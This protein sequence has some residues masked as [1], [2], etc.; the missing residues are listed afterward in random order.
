VADGW[1]LVVI[2]GLQAGLSLTL[3][4]ADTAFQDEATYL[5]AGH[6]EIAHWLHGSA[7]PAFPAY[8]SGAP[9]LYP[10]VGALAD[11]LGGLA[12]A[13][14]LS[15]L[16]MLGATA[17][18]WGSTRRL[19]G[20]RA[21]F[22]AAVLFV[23]LAPTLHLGT[24]ATYD[25]MSLFLLALATWF[26]VRAGDSQA[27]TRWLVGAGVVLAVANAVAY[28]SAAFDVVVILLALLIPMR[29]LGVKT[30]V[31]RSLTVLIV[32]GVLITAGLLIGGSE[33]THGVD[34]TTLQR[35]PGT[36]TALDV[37]G[38]AWTWTGAVLVAGACGV[39]ISWFRHEGGTQTCQLAVVTAAA[40][41]GPL[42]Q[43]RLHTAASLDK[44]VGAGAWFATIAAGYAVDK[45]IGAAPSG[46]GR[47][48]TS[49]ACV[50]A[51]ALPIAL[52]VSQ[53]RGFATSWPE[54]SD[55]VA[56]L[57]PLITRTT[58]PVLVE[59]PTVAEYYL[60]AES[61]WKRWS[62]TR[63]I[64]LPSGL[65]SGGPSQA[66]GVVGSGN[67]GT[68]AAKITS[69]YFDLVALNFTDTTWLDRQIK[70]DLSKSGRYRLIRVVP[71]G[72]IPGTN[73]IGTYLIWQKDVT[74]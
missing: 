48:V 3:V 6:L 53:A 61:Q 59:D 37:L 74:A 72:P 66:A 20:R 14:I 25:A 2:L 15:L 47:V 27:A 13:R 16:F 67:A 29:Q 69:G 73:V 5:W 63:N 52:G 71:Y 7:I 9:V 50:V 10:P 19:L 46:N 49:A 36:A 38:D 70:A 54:S 18:L 33:Y 58:G 62:S 28:A 39:L 43:A 32:G 26:V 55:L 30:A 8:L 22:F 12:A 23:V 4:W 31:S 24:F 45:V 17:L 44:H 56:V 64:V 35:V 57:R 42:L 21:A 65:S 41:I 11:S 1:P 51:L 60:Q 40:L 68:Y 34:V